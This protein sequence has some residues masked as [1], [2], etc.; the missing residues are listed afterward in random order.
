M[1]GVKTME[2]PYGN[3]LRGCMAAPLTREK[4]SAFAVAGTTMQLNAHMQPRSSHVAP[5]EEI[6]NRT[7]E[8]G[9]WGMAVW[10][11]GKDGEW[12]CFFIQDCG[13]VEDTN[14]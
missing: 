1:D 2:A 3:A 14:G 11:K 12:A 10:E 7:I 4:P 5:C 9:S 8:A 13:M 6:D